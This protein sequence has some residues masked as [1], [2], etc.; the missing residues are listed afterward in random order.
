[1]VRVEPGGE[2]SVEIRVRNTGTVVDQFA[3]EILGDAS[4][5]ASADPPVLSL[6]PDAE[7]T[8]RI[9]FR[10]PRASKPAAGPLPFGVLVRSREDPGGSVSEEG[11]VEVGA[12]L[13]PSAELIPRTSTGSL[14]G[15]HDVAIDNRGNVPATAHVEGV[16]PDRL[17]RFDFRPPVV[18]VE[19]G[20]AGFARLRVRPTQ[21]FWRGSS[22]TR[23]FQ[24]SVQPEGSTPITLPGIFVQQPL[25][26][27]WF[28]RAIAALVALVVA[29][30]LLWALVLRPSID[31]GIDQKL[32]AYG[33]TPLPASPAGSAGASGGPGASQP[34][35]PTPTPGSTVVSPGP[36]ASGQ[37]PISGRLDK[38]TNGVKA[39]AGTLLIT[40][41]VFSN[42]TGA[43][44]DLAL[45]RGSDR[46][47]VLKLEN[48]RDLDFHFVTPIVVEQGQTLLLQVP[49]CGACEPA[50]LYSGFV[51]PPAASASPAS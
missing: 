38:A 5:W 41:L 7:A 30:A 9:V 23:Q 40:D 46:L 18:G 39:E 12:F 20:A 48:F 49:D 3:L 43:S 24:V 19:A 47:L 45:M 35:G 2:A 44:G 27:S 15:G 21:R 17:V 25:L 13:E 51:Q 29:L 33:L 16:D 10:L 36:G 50:V 32:E 34:G 42:P 28:E 8:A 31:A 6:F 11:T 26:P 4:G 1:T 14:S 37:S 22:R